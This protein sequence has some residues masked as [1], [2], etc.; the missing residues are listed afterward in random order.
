MLQTYLSIQIDRTFN[1]SRKVTENVDAFTGRVRSNLEKELTKKNKK[2]KVKPSKD[3]PLP[4]TPSVPVNPPE[5]LKVGLMENLDTPLDNI[6]VQELLDKVVT[7]TTQSYYMDILGQLYKI[8][9]NAPWVTNLQMP[10]SILSGYLVYPNKLETLFC[11]KADLDFIWY[12]GEDATDLWTEVGRGYSYLAQNKDVGFQLKLKCVPKSIEVGLEFERT[13]NCS[14][15]AGPGIC[16]F[17]ERH[18]FTP[19]YLTGNQ[20]RVVSYNILA[21]LYADSDYSRDVLFGYC[22]NYAMNMDYRKQLFIKEITGYHGDIICLQEVDAKLFD[23]DL[24]TIFG[25]EKN[26]TFTFAEKRDVGEGVAILF[27]NTR[28][29]LLDTYRFDVGENIQ[30][31][32]ILKDIA[33]KLKRNEQLYKRVVERSTTLLVVVLRSLDDPKQVLI[34]ANTHLYF[35]PDADHIRLL[36]AGMCVKYLESVIVEEVKQKHVQDT[37]KMSIIFA[38]DFNSDPASGIFQLMTTGRIPVDYK[39]WGS[40]EWQFKGFCFLT[41]EINQSNLLLFSDPEEWIKDIEL[42]HPFKIGNATGC[43]LTNYTEG[44]KECLDYIYYQM[45]HL[46]VERTVPMPTEEQLSAHIAIPSIVFPSDHVA[47]VADFKF[48]EQE[49]E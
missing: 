12:R 31:L 16:P 6:T 46:Q 49:E 15:Q 30:N 35:H 14:V 39:D 33:D 27:R 28:F 37:D 48:Q 7:N 36:Q 24:T 2:K 1:F 11:T 42:E 13:A 20:F 10:S 4:D 38:G 3:A 47:L 19:F 5:E 9:L 41:G 17:E 21:D 25:E 44:F 26:Y 23:Q 18:F 45:D 32:E 40:S 22:Q 8:Q 34:V 29:T 43:S